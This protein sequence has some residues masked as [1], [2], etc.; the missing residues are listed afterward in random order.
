MEQQSGLPCFFEGCLEGSHEVVR[1][2]ADEADR[3]AEEH[4]PPIL[5]MPL[6]GARVQRG[7]KLIFDVDPGSRESV[8]KCAFAGV[9]VADKGNRVLLTTAAYLALFA[10]LDL[11]QSMA[12]IA[13][14]LIHQAA[15]LFQLCFARPP[16]ANSAG[17]PR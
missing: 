13:D 12:Q 2:V 9:G 7:E 3:I 6:P 14:P 10:C 1:K 15:I 16:Q 5:Q 8:H 17:V 11:N 4:P